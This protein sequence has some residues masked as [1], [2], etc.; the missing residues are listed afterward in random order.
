MKTVSIN[1]RQEKDFRRDVI[2]LLAKEGAHV[3]NH[4]DSWI[5]GVPDLSFGLNGVDGW[6]EL[7]DVVAIP[8]AAN[9][10]QIGFTPAQGTW[11]KKRF[12]A[13]NGNVWGLV[14][15]RRS[16]SS[17]Y[18]LF[19]G[20]QIRAIATNSVSIDNM[21]KYCFGVYTTL[22]YALRAPLSGVG[23]EEKRGENYPAP[24]RMNSIKGSLVS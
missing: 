4:E 15:V 6:I 10:L 18:W 16:A 22:P 14:R 19:R 1:Q 5:A 20:D 12:A 9:S 17:T 2:K 24:S 8:S 7:K 13:G 23:R 21:V 3:T 11:A